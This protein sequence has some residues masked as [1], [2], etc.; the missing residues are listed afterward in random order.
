MKKGIYVVG[1]EKLSNSAFLK[2]KEFIYRYGRK[3]DIAWFEYNFVNNSTDEFMKVL[4]KYQFE[5]GGFGGLVTEFE[6]SGPCLKS[7]EHAFRYIYNL[8]DRKSVV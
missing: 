7:T 2:A 4:K 8:K 3:I 1:G 6:Y 5:N